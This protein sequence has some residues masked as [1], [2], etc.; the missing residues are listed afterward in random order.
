MAIE[1]KQDADG[2]H[3]L[4]VIDG[5]ESIGGFK[6]KKDA[7]RFIK[8]EFKSRDD[9][10]RFLKRAEEIK[11]IEWWDDEQD[12]KMR[13]ILHKA[14]KAEAKKRGHR[15]KFY[16]RSFGCFGSPR[17]FSDTD[18]AGFWTGVNPYAMEAHHLWY[19]CSDD[20]MNQFQDL[21]RRKPPMN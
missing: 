1:I 18:K 2:R 3:W 6:S 7:E 13:K 16:K 14:H 15:F 9:V 10:E 19:P 11:K 12:E 8:S 20:E 5:C 4:V 17:I 21:I